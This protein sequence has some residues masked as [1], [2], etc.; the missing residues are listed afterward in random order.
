MTRLSFRRAAVTF[1]LSVLVTLPGVSRGQENDVAALRQEVKEL[2][3]LLQELAT[4]FDARLNRLEH[5]RT[6][7]TNTTTGDGGSVSSPLLKARPNDSAQTKQQ[8]PAEPTPAVERLATAQHAAPAPQVQDFSYRE[9]WLKMKDGMTQ[10]EINE[11]LGP[12]Q[13]TLTINGKTVWY[14]FYPG[15]GPA[16]VFFNPDGHA[17]SHQAPTFGIL[18]W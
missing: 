15:V 18:S 8:A 5:E 11:L 2:K 4:K 13:K 10:A 16:S 3:A 6:D 12:P 7:S 14:Y 1:A 17:S 9:R